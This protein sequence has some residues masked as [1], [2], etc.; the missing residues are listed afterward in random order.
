LRNKSF[1]KYARNEYKVDKTFKIKAPQCGRFFILAPKLK[2]I[3]VAT[4]AVVV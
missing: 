1:H 4:K 2:I 3:K